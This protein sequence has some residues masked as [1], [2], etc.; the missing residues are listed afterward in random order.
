MEN[1]FITELLESKHSDLLEKENSVQR[2]KSLEILNMR[3][4]KNRSVDDMVKILNLS[5]K[6]YLE[7]EYGDMKYSI[8]EYDKVIQEIKKSTR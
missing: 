1:D 2:K 5:E 4:D 6:E 3:L 7:Y 8:D